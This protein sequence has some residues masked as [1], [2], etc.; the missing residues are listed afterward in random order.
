LES[1]DIVYPTG[2]TAGGFVE[3]EDE[4]DAKGWVP[5][6]SVSARNASRGGGGQPRD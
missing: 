5:T 1:G 4:F 2:R 6:S 3:V